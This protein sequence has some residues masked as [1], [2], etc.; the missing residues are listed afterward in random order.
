MR[1]ANATCAA[2]ATAFREYEDA[3]LVFHGREGKGEAIR[4]Y[5][6]MYMEDESE[7]RCIAGNEQIYHGRKRIILPHVKRAR[8][9]HM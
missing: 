1:S 4:G 8:H 2:A 5:I 7:R 6:C 3:F 9:S